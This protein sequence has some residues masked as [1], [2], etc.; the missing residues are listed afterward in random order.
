M[1]KIE[2]DNEVWQYL[3]K[4]AEPFEDTPN[5]VLR[6]LLNIDST[7]D[8]IYSSK[9]QPYFPS[10]IPRALQQILEVVYLVKN[11]GLTRVEAT[12]E[13]AQKM[14]IKPQTVLDKYCRQL[15]K[16]SKQID[17]ILEE[18]IEELKDILFDKF[19]LHRKYINNFFNNY[20]VKNY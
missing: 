19:K 5:T 11:K 16:K 17:K 4:N 18:N 2:I 10:D 9:N 6:R 3:K 15:N 14:G 8:G 20:L 12:N 13:V 1:K 7:N